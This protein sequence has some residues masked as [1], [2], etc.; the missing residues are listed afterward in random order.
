M[1]YVGIIFERDNKFLLQLRDNNPEIGSPNSWGLFGGGVEKNEIP[2]KA[3][4]REI[5][6]ELGIPLKKDSINK[7]LTKKIGKETYHIFGTKFIWDL[8][9][10]K[11]NEGSAMKF[12]SKEELEQTGN[13][14]K[15]IKDLLKLVF[16]HNNA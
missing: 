4:I 11:L 15:G 16:F 7:F 3:I 12:F 5:K 14:V 1:D 10:I 2:L 6:E 8:N 9:N 13:L